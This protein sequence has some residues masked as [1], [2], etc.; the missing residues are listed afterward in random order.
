MGIDLIPTLEVQRALY[1]Q[2]RTMA[3]FRW[4]LEQ[5][6]GVSDDGEID[7]ALPIV[8]VNPLGREHCL[9]AIEALIALGAE[10]EIASAIEE[11]RRRLTQVAGEAKVCVNLLD[12]ARGGWTNRHFVE[13]EMRLKGRLA[14][15][16]KRRP[17][18]V[19][20]AWSSETY[21][22]GMLRHEALA[23]I[24]RYA[25]AITLGSTQTLGEMLTREGLALRFAGADAETAR[26]LAPRLADDEVD[27]CR[28]IILGQRESTHWP[29]QFAAFFGDEIA[30]E[31]GYPGLGLP[32]R[33]GFAVALAEATEN[34]V[35]P[36][37]ALSSASRA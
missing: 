24:F 26:L 25:A 17:F 1:A 29:A 37:E 34:G 8:A 9:A 28:A 7:I 13:A 12:D 6:T 21:E 27:Y 18:V 23:A 11:A 14:D 22:A 35:D 16:A 3:R 36:V 15:R 10:A 4:Y 31:A 33:A 2:K 5:I 30:A 20:P 19:A 32:S